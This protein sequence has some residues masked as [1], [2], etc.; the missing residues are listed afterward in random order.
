MASTLVTTR[1]DSAGGNGI[2]E[3]PIPRLDFGQDGRLAPEKWTII[4]ARSNSNGIPMQQSN[5]LMISPQ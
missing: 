5:L 3:K 1:T 2:L 4:E